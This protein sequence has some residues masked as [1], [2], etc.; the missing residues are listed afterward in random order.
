[1]QQQI[2]VM[3]EF[4]TP[5]PNHSAR[6]EREM[7]GILKQNMVLLWSNPNPTAEF[8][9]GT[10]NLDLTDYYAVICA[11]SIVIPSDINRYSAVI[12]K[13]GRPHQVFGTYGMFTT[14]SDTINFH[15]RSV[16]VTDEGVEFSRSYVKT[17]GAR[18]V[19]RQENG[20]SVPQLI[21]GLR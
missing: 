5:Q 4:F 10:I 6:R 3:Q 18:E 14:S 20:R 2:L 16:T 7:D 19:A 8:V 17:T 11:F 13:D 21:Y 1:M 9:S 15:G 12:V